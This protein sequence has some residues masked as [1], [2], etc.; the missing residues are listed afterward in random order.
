[1][2]CETT[3]EGFGD[4]NY[5]IVLET[6]EEH[7]LAQYSHLPAWER[8]DSWT[9]AFASNRRVLKRRYLMKISYWRWSMA[10]HLLVAWGWG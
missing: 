4:P 8:I 6:R 2:R 9:R 7:G 1:M 5:C 3:H 10:C